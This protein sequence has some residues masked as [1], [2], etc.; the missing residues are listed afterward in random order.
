MAFPDSVFGTTIYTNYQSMIHHSMQ[1]LVGVC[2]GIR[3][4]HYFDKDSFTGSI[5]TFLNLTAAALLANI[6]SHEYF[7][8]NGISSELNMFFISPYH[9]CTLPVLSEVYKA[10]PYPAFLCI[11]IF[12]FMLCAGLVMLI[13]KGLIKITGVSKITVDCE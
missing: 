13:M 8:Q 1:I 9:E 10:V 5:A 11:Y 4:G 2:L 6:I 12:G 7:V 3:C